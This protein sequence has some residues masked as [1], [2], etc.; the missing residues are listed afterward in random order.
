MAKTLLVVGAHADDNELGAGLTSLLALEAGYSV[1][2]LCLSREGMRAR[3]DEQGE[4]RKAAD[5][6]GYTESIMLDFLDTRFYEQQTDIIS[7]IEKVAATYSPELAITHSPH[8]SHQDH[9]TTFDAARVSLRS[10]PTL[11]M[12]EGPST[13]QT[14]FR[15]IEYQS[16]DNILLAYKK[17]WAI[18]A[19]ESQ[20][21][22]AFSSAAIAQLVSTG[23]SMHTKQRTITADKILL[24]HKG[25]VETLAEWNPLEYKGFSKGHLK[26]IYLGQLM[27]F[28]PGTMFAESFDAKRATY[29][30]K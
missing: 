9:R 19:Y 26:D 6:I 20:K 12:M 16:T 18:G 14:Y 25:L 23:R 10:V 24:L 13:D 4:W 28:P 17:A 29:N 27:M 15:P 21:D 7:E 3:K 1:I 2:N 22:I 11:L 5:R 8:D 30:W